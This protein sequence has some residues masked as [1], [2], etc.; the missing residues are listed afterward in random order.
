MFTHTSHRPM[1]FPS[2]LYSSHNW[3]KLFPAL[4]KA[5]STAQRLWHKSISTT[6]KTANQSLRNSR[7]ETVVIISR[8]ER[9]PNAL[10]FRQTPYST[11]ALFGWLLETHWGLWVIRAETVRTGSSVYREVSR[12]SFNRRVWTCQF[13]DQ[14][15][16][17]Q[18]EQNNLESGQT[19]LIFK[20]KSSTCF[21]FIDSFF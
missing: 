9:E 13:K 15:K 5:L 2:S 18:P 8:L 21:S 12:A 16:N 20:I 10:I 1:T 17:S 11:T 6:D 19:W 7:Q 14:S 4:W 3:E